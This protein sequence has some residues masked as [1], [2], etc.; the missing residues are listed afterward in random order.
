MQVP[1]LIDDFLARPALLYPDKLAVVDGDQT[2]CAGLRPL[3]RVV[4]GLQAVTRA[5]S[6]CDYLTGTNPASIAA[7]RR[8]LD[9][10]AQR[11]QGI[12]FD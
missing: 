1:L 12:R 7:Y 9:D 5:R 10:A 3:S 6:Y 11:K 2:N 8:A 4:S